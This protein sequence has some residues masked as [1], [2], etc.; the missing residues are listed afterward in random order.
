MGVVMGKMSRDKGKRGE[1]EVAHLLQNYGYDA[2]RGCQYHGGPDSPDVVGLPG[3]HIEVKRTER[4]DLYGAME[5]TKRD[6][7]S[8][9]P[10]VF[11]RRNGKEWLVI[12]RA[13]DWLEDLR[14][15]A[16]ITG[17]WLEGLNVEG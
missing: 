8:D 3:Y 7:G 1:A 2:K 12:L 15:Y 16:D 9:T 17:K 4:L 14:C 10:V 6:A 11:H 13:E 5:Q